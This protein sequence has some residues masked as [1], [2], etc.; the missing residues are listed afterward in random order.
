[1]SSVV[2]P[3]EYGVT[4]EEK[5]NIGIKVVKRLIEKIHHDLI[6]WMSPD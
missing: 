1:M 2:V 6:W 4:N 5:L 3:L